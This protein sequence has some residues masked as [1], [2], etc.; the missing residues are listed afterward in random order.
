MRWL[1]DA[2]G[3]ADQVE[4]DSAGIGNWHAGERADR[5]AAAAAQRRGFR[6]DGVARQV[7]AEDFETF[8][9]LLAMDAGHLGELRSMAPPGTAVKVRMFTDEDVPDPYYGGQNGFENVLDIVEAGCSAL[10]D[11]LRQD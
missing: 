5:R 6:V 10:L 4:V 8:D 3:L 9:L 11:E 2:H 1:V 7:T